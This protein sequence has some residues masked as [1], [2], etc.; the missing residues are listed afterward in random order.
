MLSREEE[1]RLAQR[2]ARGDP[3]AREALIVANQGL[4]G[5]VLHREFRA[6]SHLWEDLFQEG[7]VGLIKAVDRFDWRRGCRFSTYAVW[8]IRREIQLALGRWASGAARLPE[9]RLREVRELDLAVRRLGDRLHRPPTP[10][11]VAAELGAPVERV[12]ELL[13]QAEAGRAPLSMDALEDERRVL[14]FGPG[15]LPLEDESLTLRMRHALWRAIEHCLTPKQREVVLLRYGL[16]PEG[17]HR[18]PASQREIAARMNISPQAVSRLEERALAR[19]KAEMDLFT[20]Y[21]YR[22]A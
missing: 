2:V 5:H 15:P 3:A 11:E 1:L 16:D 7:Q 13:A 12:P 17:K 8:W 18:P 6:F 22:G 21:L 19:I 10:A 9:A 14:E 4:I 20:L